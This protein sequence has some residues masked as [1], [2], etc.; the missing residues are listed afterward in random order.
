M[1]ACQSPQDLD[2]QSML[3]IKVTTHDTRQMVSPGLNA[4]LDP[5][6]HPCV[7]LLFLILAR[8][9]LID[10]VVFMEGVC[11]YPTPI[12]RLPAP[13]GSIPVCQ[14]LTALL[15]N[16]QC[17]DGLWDWVKVME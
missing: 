1:V 2:V 6:S 16:W 5:L 17:L 14:F 13:T 12:L 11:P 4:L 10:V 3:G 15:L 9:R 7:G 8:Y